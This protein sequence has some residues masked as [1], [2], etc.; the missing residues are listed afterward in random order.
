MAGP[1]P[2]LN[3]GEAFLKTFED[4]VC[5]YKKMI[6]VIKVV[7]ANLFSNLYRNLIKI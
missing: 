7:L 2:E 1:A 4:L 5:F 6:L 3:L